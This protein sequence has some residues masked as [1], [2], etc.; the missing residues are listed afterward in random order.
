[1]SP[2]F[3]ARKRADEFDTLVEAAASGRSVDDARFGDLLELVGTLREA[4][5]VE[6]RP[7]F[8]ADL[9]ERLM[10]AAATELSPVTPAAA[11]THERLTVA[12]RRTAR[13][14]RLAVAVGGLAIV[15]A[16]T[17]MAMAAQSALPGDVLYPLKRAMEN[18]HTGVSVGDSSKGT[19][20][21]AHT[22]L[23]LANA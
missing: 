8:V 18:A 9:R 16:S 21:L 14:R 1:M 10:T 15:G 2:V 7:E 6:A 12:P 19:T 13:E 22:L 4:P 20:L 11:S 23:D 5:H 17:S 3:S